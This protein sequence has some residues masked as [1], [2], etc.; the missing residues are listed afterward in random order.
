MAVTIM[1]V[2]LQ[3]GNVSSDLI[4]DDIIAQ[5]IK[6]STD[7]IMERRIAGATPLAIDI[8]VTLLAAY[9]VTL[10][11]YDVLTRDLGRTPELS[12]QKLSTMWSQFLFFSE[13]VIGKVIKRE[14]ALAAAT[15][16]IDEYNP[17]IV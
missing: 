12:A 15:K 10:A 9:N 14:P 1:D 5:Q 7:Y 4:S 3:L 8:S 16:L 13:G 6:Y 11:Y 17:T 2:R